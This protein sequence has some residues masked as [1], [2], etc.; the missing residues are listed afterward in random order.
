MTTHYY[1]K[2]ILEIFHDEFWGFFADY[3]IWINEGSETVYEIKDIVQIKEIVQFSRSIVSD[4]LWPH[5]TAARQASLS[6]TNSW[7]LLKLMHVHRVGDAIQPSY[8]LSSP[9]PP[10]FNLSKHHTN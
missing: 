10:A 7:S 8:P 3:V 9:S 1:L 4:S 2:W 5:G 6:I